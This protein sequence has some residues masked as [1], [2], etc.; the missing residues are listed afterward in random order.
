MHERPDCGG[1]ECAEEHLLRDRR[2]LVGFCHLLFSAAVH[3]YLESAVALHVMELFVIERPFY[4]YLLYSYKAA[5]IDGLSR[6]APYAVPVQ[7]VLEF[8]AG[9]RYDKGALGLPHQPL[10]Y[11]RPRYVDGGEENERDDSLR[12]EVTEELFLVVDLGF[13]VL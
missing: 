6:N 12:V 7:N 13:H 10:H 3:H 1:V 4:R 9:R 8:L 11:R 2:Y 5:V